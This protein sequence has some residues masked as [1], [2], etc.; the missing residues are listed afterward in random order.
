MRAAARCT[1]ADTGSCAVPSGCGC[2]RSIGE[3]AYSLDRAR[4]P[5]L[6]DVLAAVVDHLRDAAAFHE[7]AVA[8]DLLGALVDAEDA[9]HQAA[10]AESQ[11][12]GAEVLD[13]RG[14][15]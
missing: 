6:V 13:H 11:R 12:L 4:H 1:S 2:A 10:H 5:D 14:A 9:Q 7:A 15:E 3:S 8:V